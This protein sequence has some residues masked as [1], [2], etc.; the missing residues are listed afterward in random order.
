MRAEPAS[1]PLPSLTAE[2]A[3]P[4][5]IQDKPEARRGRKAPGQVPQRT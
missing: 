2:S 1:T 3:V 5:S 4:F